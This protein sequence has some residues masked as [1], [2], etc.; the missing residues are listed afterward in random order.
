MSAEHRLMPGRAGIYG[1]HPGFGDFIA[2]GLPDIWPGFGDWLQSALGHWREGAGPDWQAQFDASPVLRFWIGPA[3][4]G[5]AVGLRGVM[6]P[7]RDRSGRR[8]P[9]VIAQTGGPAPVLEPAQGF[10]DAAAQALTGLVAEASFD[11]RAGLDLPPPGDATP[12]WPGFWAGNPAL[13]P[14]DLLAQLAVADHAHATAARSYWW[15]GTGPSG[16]VCAQGWPGPAEMDW[17]IRAGIPAEV[18]A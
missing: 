4:I 13:A 5:G 2:A 7:S 11:P 12:G 3:V 14:Q 8:F 18:K 15:F 9:L 16:V 1:K 17:L 6:A 10:Y